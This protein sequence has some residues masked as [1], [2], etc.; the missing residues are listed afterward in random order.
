ML[1]DCLRTLSDIDVQDAQ[2]ASKDPSAEPM[3]LEI[4]V[5]P[6]I[7][8]DPTGTNSASDQLLEGQSEMFIG[9]KINID[10]WDTFDFKSMK[11]V[12]LNVMCKSAFNQSR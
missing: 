11:S 12:H 8:V 4:D 5:S 9:Q 2:N 6:F 10:D 7:N 1:S 3:D